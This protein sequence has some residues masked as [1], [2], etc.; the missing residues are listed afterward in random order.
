[1]TD[2]LRKPIRIPM[3]AS[4]AAAIRWERPRAVSFMPGGEVLIQIVQ[5]HNVSPEITHMRSVR[6]TLPA[7]SLLEPNRYRIGELG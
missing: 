7:A 1:M 2:R 5:R 4:V 6:L 3:G